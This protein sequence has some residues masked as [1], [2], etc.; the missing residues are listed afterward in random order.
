MFF[1]PVAAKFILP[2]H[3]TTENHATSPSK[4]AGNQATQTTPKSLT[5][6][7]TT[8]L[9]LKQVTAVDIHLNGTFSLK[10][11]TPIIWASQRLLIFQIINRETHMT[12]LFRK[13]S[14]ASIC[15]LLSLPSITQAYFRTYWNDAISFT[16]NAQITNLHV[17]GDIDARVYQK[18][19]LITQKWREPGGSTCQ[20]A[21]RSPSGSGYAECLGNGTFSFSLDFNHG[22][23]CQISIRDD[24]QTKQP[25][26]VSSN[27]S[28]SFSKRS[29]HEQDIMTDIPLSTAT[30]FTLSITDPDFNPQTDISTLGGN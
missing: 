14:L 25:I 6:I 18:T 5:P 1:V 7:A 10:S 27:C 19:I 17:T 15:C 11:L 4:I 29:E 3:Q 8:L 28:Y 23:T 21:A 22:K 20:L 24:S 2:I 13:I 16:P 30:V 12:A 9:A 26:I